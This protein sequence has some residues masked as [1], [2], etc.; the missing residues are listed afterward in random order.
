MEPL[1]DHSGLLSLPR[2]L[3]DNI[4]L[5]VLDVKHPLY[6]FKEDNSDDV[7][8]FAPRTPARWLALLHTNRKIHAEACET[9]YGRH[10]FVFVDTAKSQGDLLGVFLHKIGAVNAGY[11]THVCI[12][13][14]AMIVDRQDQNAA[15]KPDL[16]ELELLQERCGS[17][18]TLEAFVY[19]QN[20]KG[21]VAGRYSPTLGSLSTPEALL[22][23]DAKFKA[24]PSLPAVLIK[25][26]N[27]PLAPEVVELMQGFGWVISVGR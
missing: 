13:F 2:E 8:V 12:N 4:Y 9:L 24:I 10:K 19:G 23:V 22:Q 21:L 5:N 6:L 1:N 14:P 27:G 20:S 17:L 16:L 15:R 25:P 18:R 26:S 3:R 7:E 11:L